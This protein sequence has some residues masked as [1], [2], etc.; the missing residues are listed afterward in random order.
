MMLAHAATI[1]SSFTNHAVAGIRGVRIGRGRGRGDIIVIATA[2]FPFAGSRRGG[3]FSA[4]WGCCSS[5]YPPP[6]PQRCPPTL[7]GGAT[8]DEGFGGTA[9]ANPLLHQRGRGALR[10][11]DHAGQQAR[12]PALVRHAQPCP[13]H[14]QH[15][16]RGTHAHDEARAEGVNLLLV[17]LRCRVGG[18]DGRTD[19]DDRACHAPGEGAG[20]GRRPD[21]GRCQGHGRR[22]DQQPE[23]RARSVG[24]IHELP[25]TIGSDVTP[26]CCGTT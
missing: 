6:P 20:E 21:H 11:H 23:S 15:Q 4:L 3:G 18:D 9:T 2:A 7:A 26:T 12:R 17:L 13:P 22:G 14:P 1:S 5:P 8:I 24:G 25:V 10:D 19:P 16:L